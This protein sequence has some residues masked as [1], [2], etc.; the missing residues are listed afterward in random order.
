LVQ[1]SSPGT[2]VLL[3]SGYFPDGLEFLEGWKFLRKPFSPGV[4]TE[5]LEILLR[6]A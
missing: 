3:M 6:A 4:L 1:K 2:K 5:A